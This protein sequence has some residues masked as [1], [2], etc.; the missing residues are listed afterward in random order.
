[1]HGV[2]HICIEQLIFALCKHPL[3]RDIEET[4]SSPRQS[5]EVTGTQRAETEPVVNIH[6]IHVVH[7]ARLALHQKTLRAAHGAKPRSWRSCLRTTSS[8]ATLPGYPVSY[9]NKRILWP[10]GKLKRKL[11]TLVRFGVWLKHECE[12]SLQDQQTNLRSGVS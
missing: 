5:Q 1:M 2:H 7:Y 12:N 3:R 10:A 9:G 11:D 4:R 6:V 8:K